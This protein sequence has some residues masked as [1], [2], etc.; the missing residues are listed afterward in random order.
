MAYKRKK[1]QA[2]VKS[3]GKFP[4]KGIE[5]NNTFER[6][7]AMLLDEADIPFEFEPKTFML[8]EPFVFPLVSYERQSNQ[9]GLMINRGQKKVQGIKY[10]PDFVGEGFIIETK[11]YANE[12]FPMRWKLFK[13]L[14]TQQGVKTE[15]LVIFKPQ[16]ISELVEVVK[17]IKELKDDKFKKNSKQ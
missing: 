8:V 3:K 9:K 13:N 16:K 11:G 4:F 14:L 1:G 17:L 12:T 10:T 5:Y 2:I 7:M 6:K 15:D